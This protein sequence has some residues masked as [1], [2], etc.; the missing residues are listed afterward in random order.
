MKYQVDD[1]S[2]PNAKTINGYAAATFEVEGSN[3]DNKLERPP[4]GGGSAKCDDIHPRTTIVYNACF[5]QFLVPCDPNMIQNEY[6]LPT[7]SKQ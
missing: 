7:G 4:T 2:G 3:R 1:I 5:L 6:M